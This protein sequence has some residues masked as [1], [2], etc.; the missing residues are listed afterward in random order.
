MYYI[1]I[2]YYAGLQRQEGRLTNYAIRLILA[3]KFP[4]GL[5]LRRITTIYGE[6]ETLR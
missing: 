4:L 3:S 2:N 5:L 6:N 1:Y